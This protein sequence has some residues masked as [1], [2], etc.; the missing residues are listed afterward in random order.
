MS[1]VFDESEDVT[2]EREEEEEEE[3]EAEEGDNVEDH[4]SVTKE[5][6]EEED[7]GNNKQFDYRGPRVFSQQTSSFIHH[8]ISREKDVAR[9]RARVAESKLD[10]NHRA[11][12]V[13]GEL[14]KRT[15][16]MAKQACACMTSIA[17]NDLQQTQRPYLVSLVRLYVAFVV[18]KH[19]TALEEKT[20]EAKKLQH[21]RCTA[22]TLCSPEC[23]H[24]VARRFLSVKH[25]FR[26]IVHYQLEAAAFLF[27]ALEDS[28]YP[29]TLR[30][31]AEK[32]PDVCK[33]DVM[34]KIAAIRLV[35]RLR[36]PAVNDKSYWQRVDRFATRYVR[37]DLKLCNT[38][39]PTS[40]RPSTPTTFAKKQTKLLTVEDV[41]IVTHMDDVLRRVLATVASLAQ[42]R[43]YQM[44]SYSSSHVAA[45][46]VFQAC[47]NMFVA[48]SQSTV[49]ISSLS[50]GSSH[51]INV[52]KLLCAITSLL[53]K[54]QKK[55]ASVARMRTMLYPAEE[56]LEEIETLKQAALVEKQHLQEL[57]HKSRLSAVFG[58]VGAGGA[59][60]ND[61][62]TLKQELEEAEN[63]YRRTSSKEK[64]LSQ[65]I[66]DEDLLLRFEQATQTKTGYFI[67]LTSLQRDLVHMSN[68]LQPHIDAVQQKSADDVAAM[69]RRLLLVYK[70]KTPDMECVKQ[71]QE[72]E[73]EQEEQKVVSSKRG[74]KR[75]SNA[76][77]HSF[78]Q[79]A[80]KEEEMEN[81]RERRQA[82]HITNSTQATHR[83]IRLRQV[84]VA[85]VSRLHHTKVSTLCSVLWPAASACIDSPPPA[86][87]PAFSSPSS[88]SAI[89]SL[90]AGAGAGSTSSRTIK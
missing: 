81:R 9:K 57:Q 69:H 22:P 17:F 41:P 8:G 25:P 11:E 44:L 12:R 76:K 87:A 64:K 3:E 60:V 55:E 47:K 20:T 46:C 86:F 33:A 14:V 61:T 2:V 74:V 62:N 67:R 6:E 23:E 27:L 32:V 84:H 56:V 5:E 53:D 18:T 59:D 72:Q 39:V 65:H 28:V 89:D 49:L 75:K 80:A 70:M 13:M 42:S 40:P 52:R 29:L 37:F 43:R 63:A 85:E 68:K 88:S 38:S 35:V 77:P 45:A 15:L 34:H 16:R 83:N 48:V 66:G 90:A 7:E 26:P 73:Q 4:E 78:L 10:V 19:Q 30:D 79:M 1:Q 71:E 82:L 50:S 36:T 31:L 24:N 58:T 54:I 51:V 21:E